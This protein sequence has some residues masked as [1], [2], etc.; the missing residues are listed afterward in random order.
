MVLMLLE[1]TESAKDAA[2]VGIAHL[3]WTFCSS[4]TTHT[5]KF[6]RAAAL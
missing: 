3:L 2:I 4:K 6:S 5:S 1:G